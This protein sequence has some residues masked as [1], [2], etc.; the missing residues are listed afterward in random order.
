MKKY[1]MAICL[2][3]LLFSCG[4]D[5]GD[6]FKF[7]Q[8]SLQQTSWRGVITN[9]LPEHTKKQ[10]SIG[11]LFA[12]DKRG[13]YEYK[14]ADDPEARHEDF[15]YEINGKLLIIS[16]SIDGI[17]PDLKGD[18]MLIES[19]KDRLVL[20]RG[21]ENEYNRSITLELAKTY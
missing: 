20:T 19:G 8:N 6:Q 15:Q 7:D 4:D 3:L 12:T 9:T 17:S 5:E 11:I 18:W 13:S 10:G 2:S 1:L 14:Y 16:N 21:I